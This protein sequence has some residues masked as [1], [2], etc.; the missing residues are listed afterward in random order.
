MKKRVLILGC[1]GSIGTS[2]LNIIREFPS[3]YEVCGL[4]AHSNKQK[5]VELSKEF[6]CSNISLSSEEDNLS[7]II[8]VS[9]AN[10]CVNGISGGAGLLPSLCCLENGIDLALANKE[11]VV[12]AW[13]I[14]QKTAL[15][16]NCK[17]IPV[18]SEHSAVFSMIE[19][20][21]R[22]N[23]RNIT[24]TASGGPFRT[25]SYEQLQSVTV[26]NALNHPTWKMGKK[27]SI[28]SATLAN[29][30]LEVIEASRL[31]NFH[32]KDIG[33]TVHPQ[34]LVHSF[35]TTNDGDLYAQISHPDM[36]RPILSALSYPNFAANSFEKFDFNNHFEMTFSPPNRENFPLL[37]LAFNTITLG[38]SYSIAYN[39]ANE[40]AVDLFLKNKISFLEISNIVKR[41]LD[42]DWSKEASTIEEVLNYDKKAREIAR[43]IF[44]D[45]GK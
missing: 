19:R 29:K 3:E 10:I 37:S 5:L 20:Y 4:S 45:I 7:T 26:E 13:N 38:G 8:K 14:I 24:L 34:S 30:G 43:N 39:A 40:I 41:T 9:N 23:I 21:G 32:E 2:T 27:I 18:D 28:D 11:T 36:R 15:K 16:N 31:F 44:T 12:M 17:I 25:Y 42:E 6:N 35:V 33:V 22:Q 1:T